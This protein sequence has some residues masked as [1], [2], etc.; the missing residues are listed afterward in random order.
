MSSHRSL[1]AIVLAVLV[2][3]AWGQDSGL[4]EF[5]PAA[6]SVFEPSATEL[7]RLAKFANTSRSREMMLRRNLSRF[8]TVSLVPSNAEEVIR[9]LGTLERMSRD[10]AEE[11]YRGAAESSRADG[12]ASIRLQDVQ[13]IETQ[14]LPARGNAYDEIVIFPE[15][16]RGVT[17][18]KMDLQAFYDTGISLQ[19]LAFLAES[20]IQAD[21]EALPMDLEAVR[22]LTIAIN[23]YGLLLLRIGGLLVRQDLSP[24]MQSRHLRS[25]GKIV[26]QQGAGLPLNTAVT[27]STAADQRWFVDVTASSGVSFRH[28]SSY[29]ISRFRRYGYVA[30]SFSGGGVSA[31][32]LN[33]DRWV[34]LIVCGGHGC[35]VFFNRGDGTFAD[36]TTECGLH[37]DG[38]ARMAVLA[39]FDNDGQTDV[40]I[41]Y[42]RDTNRLFRN[43]GNGRFQDI[44]EG[45]GLKRLGD[46]SGPAM[47]VDY[48]ND[49]L[50]D[51]YVGNFGNYLVGDTPWSPTGSDNGMP[52]QLYRS[53]GEFKFNDVTEVAGVGNT[54]WTQAL[55]HLDYDQ[56]GDQDL[57][58][59]NDFGAN[60]LLINNGDGTFT[61]GGIATGSND[62]YHGMNV[63]FADLNRDRLADIFVTNLWFWTPSQ[64]EVTETNSLL[65][66]SI[67]ADGTAGFERFTDP[68]FLQHDT[69]WSW[70]SVFFDAEND[71][72]D[73]LY[74]V[75]G[76]TDYLTFVQYRLSPNYPGEYY[77]INNGSE[78]NWFFRNDDG[79]PIHHLSASG[80]EIPGV[81]S[82]GISP[83]DFD[84]DGD[85]DLAVSTFHSTLRLLRNDAGTASSHWLELELVGDPAQGTS[86]DAVGAQV[87]ATNG[88]GLYIWRLRTGGEGYLSMASPEIEMGLGDATEVDLEIIWPGNRRETHSAVPA[89]SRLR[90]RQGSSQPEDLGPR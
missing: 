59:A 62:P 52:N 8:F 16:P 44:T 43:L 74:V 55:S 46:I 84:G 18:E 47:A 33:P 82:R 69:G 36:V 34:D 83:L 56:D 88:T 86:R 5:T 64:Q 54:G 6:L 1:L 26:S 89:N 11:I 79:L 75:N 71:G 38:E 61:S 80:A 49:G 73:D 17:I 51:I 66:S 67:R 39:D 37:V 77:A 7:D 20:K 30:P 12:A 48:D 10:M 65:L 3:P 63:A 35:G 60:D 78:P 53:L 40:F 76:F 2:S 90:I 31:G 57:Y 68:E 70:G 19:V 24:H 25:A 29:W 27:S 72:D 85:L 21:P 23:R 45:S 50:L 22:A 13:K 58:I 32:H 81:N 41:T 4:P 9:L 87:I 14:S 15:A 42:A 28:V